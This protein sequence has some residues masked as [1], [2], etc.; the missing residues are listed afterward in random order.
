MVD[1]TKRPERSPGPLTLAIDI[2]GTHLKAGVLLIP[3]TP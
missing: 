1:Q 3:A 2:G